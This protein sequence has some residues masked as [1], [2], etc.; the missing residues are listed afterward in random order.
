MAWMNMTFVEPRRIWKA[1]R[2]G[3]TKVML[4]KI[5]R[6]IDAGQ[7][8][9]LGSIGIA[10]LCRPDG[11]VQKRITPEQSLPWLPLSRGVDQAANARSATCFLST[12]LN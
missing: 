5:L 10:M 8:P 11:R 6:Q 1:I 2:R 3:S 9:F 4:A 7:L 12:R